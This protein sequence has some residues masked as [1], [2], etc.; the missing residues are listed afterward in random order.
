MTVRRVDFTLAVERWGLLTYT[1]GRPAESNAVKRAWFPVL[2][3][4]HCLIPLFLLHQL[5]FALLGEGGNQRAGWTK[6]KHDKESGVMGGNGALNAALRWAEVKGQRGP[7]GVLSKG[8]G[9]AGFLP[10]VADG[11][12]PMHFKKSHFF[13]CQA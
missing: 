5:Q 1:Q 4:G 3:S 7:K 2:P 13:I 6:G 10:A 11:Y 12:I 8:S 9:R